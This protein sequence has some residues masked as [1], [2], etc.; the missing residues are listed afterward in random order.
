MD[1]TGQL[2]LKYVLDLQLDSESWWQI[3]GL[4]QAWFPSPPSEADL[5]TSYPEYFQT[6]T[7]TELPTDIMIET[8]TVT[9]A[10]TS[11][12]TPTDT[13]TEAPTSTPADAPTP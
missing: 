10:H 11:T 1:E 4:T 2:L 7:P 13:S 6:V 9:P 3:D 12:I 8:P 5:M